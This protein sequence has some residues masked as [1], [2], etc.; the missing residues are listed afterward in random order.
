MTDRT[1]ATC[2]S[3]TINNPTDADLRPTLPAKWVLTGQIEQGKE[4]TVHYQ[5]MLTTTQVWR[6]AVKKILPRAHI[7]PAKNKAALQKYVSKEDTRLSKVDD[8]VSDIPTLFDYQHTIAQQWDDDEFKDFQSNFPDDQLAKLGMGEIAL[9]YVDKLVALDIERGLI[10]IEYIAI[11]PMWR[12]AWKKF[13]KAMILRER[14]PVEK[15]SNEIIYDEIP[16]PSPQGIQ[17]QAQDCTTPP[18]QSE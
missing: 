13:W 3:I 18:S 9:Q 10:G 15:I 16:T 14:I 2:W 6:S 5:G 7:E 4:G 17:T 12:S 11:N 8:I 1:R